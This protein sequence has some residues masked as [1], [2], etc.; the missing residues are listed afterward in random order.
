M[1]RLYEECVCVLILLYQGQLYV[2]GGRNKVTNKVQG[3]F[4][5]IIDKKGRLFNTIFIRMLAY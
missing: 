1:S 5:F 3:Q 2:L 4:N